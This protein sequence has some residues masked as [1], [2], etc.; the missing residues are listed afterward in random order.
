[1]SK[2]FEQLQPIL[3][4]ENAYSMA[5]ALFS[6]DNATQAP[7]GAINNTANAMGILSMESYNLMIN[8]HVKELLNQLATPAEQE[9]LTFNEKAIV[10]ECKKSLDDLE[11]IPPEEYQAFV[12]LITQANPIWEK[13]KNTNDYSYFK[14]TLDQVLMYSKKFAN[15]CKKEGQSEYDYHLN[16]NEEG[17]T[18]SMC[19]EFFQKLK[20]SLIPLMRQV[21]AKK[22]QIRVDFM[23]RS[24][25]IEKQH[26]LCDML[27][28]H[29][30][31]D[32]NYGITGETEHPFT[33]SLHNKDVRFTNHF[34]ENA[35]VS[36]IFSAIHE[37]GHALYEMGVSDDISLSPVGG[38]ATTAMHE[39]Q[40]RLYENNLARSKEFWIPLWDKVVALFPDQLSDVTLDEFILAINKS[41][42][43]LIR[44][45]ADELTYA[46][47]VM[48]RYELERM[49]F[50]GDV[51]VDTLPQK[52]NDLYEEYLGVRP[53]NDTTGV[54]QDMH[55]T[56]GFGY[57]PSYAIGSAIS[58]QIM[59]SMKKVLPVD[60]LLTKGD[61][62]P[63]REYLKEHV[64]QYG[65]TKTS[66]EMLLE[67]TGEK[68]NPQYFVDYLTEK[69]TR[70]FL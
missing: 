39:S 12:T 69:Y 21:H 35:F 67:M 34:H 7:K 27:A 33:L 65:R 49:L 60:E 25:D 38:G 48:V 57:F 22:D 68:F 26:E 19:D 31:F 32:R 8:D 43:S 23:S 47:H 4:K 56:S 24:F 28:D 11:K 29:I 40:S 58:A 13:A 36:A 66:E 2:L 59:N 6:W 10:K 61:L 50:N 16:E 46:F 1:M 70:L 54:L 9:L 18:T 41:E 45:E 14:D 20:E 64:H 51:T 63:I 17:F 15:Y 37:G 62:M 5:M 3:E 52:W 44:T 42:P 55:W 30:G 53:E